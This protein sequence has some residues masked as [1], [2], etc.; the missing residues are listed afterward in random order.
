MRFVEFHELNPSFNK[1]S[2]SDSNLFQRRRL[3][4]KQ[5]HEHLKILEVDYEKQYKMM[6]ICFDKVLK[7][8]DDNQKHILPSFSDPEGFPA[9]NSSQFEALSSVLES[10]CLFADVILHL[11]EMSRT[12]LKKRP[13]WKKTIDWALEFSQSLIYITD[14]VTQ[15]LLVTLDYEINESKRPTSYRNPYYKQKLPEITKDKKKTK[16]KLKKGPQMTK[17]EL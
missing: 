9:T 11:P 15:K 17:I 13:N 7:V 1:I 16:K 5:L 3:E 2:C 4:Q 12:V 10:T 8:L 14:D 6:E